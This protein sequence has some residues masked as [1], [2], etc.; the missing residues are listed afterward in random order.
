C[1]DERR[2]TAVRVKYYVLYFIHLA[3]RKVHVAGMTPHPDERWMVQIAR[4]LTMAD[5]GFLTPGQYL[6]HDHDG[7]FC[8]AFQRLIE[9]AGVKRVPLPPRSPNLNAY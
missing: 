8:P 1:T 5:W 6:I 3:S 4:N 9:G 7:K 2:R